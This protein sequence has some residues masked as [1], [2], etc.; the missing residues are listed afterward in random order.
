MKLSSRV[1]VLASLLCACTPE[2]AAYEPLGEAIQ[3]ARITDVKSGSATTAGLQTATIITYDIPDNCNARISATV[4]AWD[5]GTSG[6]WEYRTAVKRVSGGDVAVLGAPVDLL[7]QQGKDVG[8]ATW[9]VSFA[10]NG[11]ALELKG[12][13]ILLADITWS[14]SERLEIFVP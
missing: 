1:L 14:A 9:G 3:A 6:V 12:T 13:G 10:A 5:D 11:D 8:A 4:N 7:G 2:G